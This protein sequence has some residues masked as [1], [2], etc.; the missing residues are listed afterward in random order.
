MTIITEFVSNNHDWKDHFFFVNDASVEANGISIFRT[1]WGRKETNPLPPN[2][3]GLRISRNILRGGPSIWATFSPKRVTLLLSTILGFSQTC[4]SWKCRSQAWMGSS[5][6]KFERG[7]KGQ[8]LANKNMLSLMMTWPMGGSSKVPEFTKAS[9]MVNGSLIMMNRAL[10]ASNQDARMAQF[11]A[12]TAD[13]ENARLKDELECSR[14]SERGS[15]QQRF[16]GSYK[17]LKDPEYS[18]DVEYARQTR[19]VNE[20][21]KD[22]VIPKI[23]ERIW[24]QW[25]PIP[26]SPDTVEAE[27]EAVGV[28][29]GYDGINVGNFPKNVL[30]EKER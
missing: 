28:K 30:F 14:P 25:D 20:R 16:I 15:L 13:K 22:F 5:R 4:R 29:I 17:A 23:E 1:R 9:R 26:A 18:F 24:E 3:E 27:T 12:E 10:D 6:V 19:R 11:R 8:G 21:D 7:G 2:L